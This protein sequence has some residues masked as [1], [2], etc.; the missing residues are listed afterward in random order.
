MPLKNTSDKSVS[1]KS[2]N[3]LSDQS[4]NP[5][6]SDSFDLKLIPFF[7]GKGDV[8]EFIKECEYL[9]EIHKP[10]ERVKF[11]AL[12]SSFKKHAL[13][14]FFF[15]SSDDLDTSEKI[16]K[17]LERRFGIGGNESKTNLV[18][19]HRKASSYQIYKR[20]FEKQ[21]PGETVEDVVYRFTNAWKTNL[22]FEEMTMGCRDMQAIL[23]ILIIGVLDK[24]IVDEMTEGFYSEKLNDV[25]IEAKMAEQRLKD[26]TKSIEKQDSYGTD[27]PPY[28]YYPVC[29]S[30]GHQ[31]FSPGTRYEM[32]QNIH[33][34]QP[35]AAFSNCSTPSVRQ[36]KVASRF[37][38]GY[39]NRQTPFPFPPAKYQ[40]YPRLN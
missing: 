26:K 2:V 10:S 30:K 1:D 33:D 9:F 25:V 20:I 5:P 19:G 11:I 35:N 39:E 32:E 8:H 7:D 38:A 17:W 40:R 23:S 13:N 34:M 29:A 18:K 37:N 24:A 12:A 14:A 36:V 22:R 6:K 27:P 21:K 16:F 4:E 15:S 31:T 3:P 28:F